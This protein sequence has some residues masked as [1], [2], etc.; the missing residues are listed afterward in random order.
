[1]KKYKVCVDDNKTKWYLNGKLHREDGPAVELTN[2]SKEW[3]LNGN[4][5]SEKEFNQ[6]TSKT[7]ELTVE[8]ISNL[9]GYEVKI[10]K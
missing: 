2:G 9:L 4:R 5:L 3:Y 8:E 6:K 10:V 1:M 7:K